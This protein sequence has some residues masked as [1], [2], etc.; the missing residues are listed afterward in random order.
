[1][2]V[3][4]AGEADQAIAELYR[5]HYRELVRIAVLLAGQPG[6]PR[7]AGPADHAR[8]GQALVTGETG[9]ARQASHAGAAGQAG[10][11]GQAEQIVQ[12]AFVGLHATWWQ[13]ADRRAALAYL[14]RSVLAGTRA[15][16][17]PVVPLRPAT[18]GAAAP[19]TAGP[20]G[21]MAAVGGL[22]AEQREA[23]VLALYAD[24]PM[25][26]IAAAMD[27]SPD[28]AARHLVSA[29]AALASVAGS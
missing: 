12:D 19:A 21:V 5:L 24:L 3:T 28:T 10:P 1:M 2:A 11:A 23:L 14:H 4:A 7:Q 29:K 26:E 13:V 16:A 9:P 20:G 27:V 6:Q 22:P 15:A 25:P 8:S 17:R 18:A